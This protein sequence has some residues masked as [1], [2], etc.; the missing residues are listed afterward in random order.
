MSPGCCRLGG[1]LVGFPVRNG[2]GACALLFSPRG[3]KPGGQRETVA[4]VESEWGLENEVALAAGLQCLSPEMRHCGASATCTEF[5]CPSF[6]EVAS[7]REGEGCPVSGPLS[8]SECS[9][10]LSWIPLSP[11]RSLGRTQAAGGSMSSAAHVPGH[12]L[13]DHRFSCATVL[14]RE[15]QCPA[16]G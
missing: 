11:A 6:P 13:T 9:P 4:F 12:H 15:G 1:P 14:V 8:H 7:Q 16:S 2:T 5:N 3:K 10:G